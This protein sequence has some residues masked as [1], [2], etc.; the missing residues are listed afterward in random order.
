MTV[1]GL[2]DFLSAAIARQVRPAALRAPA[3]APVAPA[4]TTLTESAPLT[5]TIS[6]QALDAAP[7][8]SSATNLAQLGTV[9]QVGQAGVAKVQDI[10]QQLQALAGQAAGPEVSSATL[11]KINTQFQQLL[12]QIN[13]IAAGTTF[14]GA[15]LLD[16]TFSGQQLATPEAQGNAPKISLPE[17][18]LASLFGGAQPSVLT[19]EAA[20]QALQQLGNAKNVT[21][22]AA[23]DL[24]DAQS[25]VE[26][27][28]A[29]VQTALA[30]IDASSA[31][32]TD[33]DLQGII[34]NIL[35]GLLSEPAASASVQTANLSPSLLSLLQE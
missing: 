22:E 15:P 17:L 21:S 29:S 25:Q 35:G 6:T 14:N 23:S 12:A 20:A 16:G 19:P 27:A 2:Q 9:L 24:D 4:T 1:I 34:E 26:F 13:R 7:Y 18:T 11:A 31:T 33:A 3:S 8:T 28:S 30:N 10:L 32:I 5:S